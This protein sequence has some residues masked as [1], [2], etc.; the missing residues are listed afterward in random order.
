TGCQTGRGAR[1]FEKRYCVRDHRACEPACRALQSATDPPAVNGSRRGPR[2]GFCSGFRARAERYDLRHCRRVSGLHDIAGARCDAEMRKPRTHEY[3]G[4]TVPAGR[5]FH[6][7]LLNPD[8]NF[9]K[10]IQKTKSGVSVILGTV[11]LSNPV[12][13]LSSPKTRWIFERL[14][15]EFAIIIV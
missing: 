8:D 15:Q 10:Y 11:P 2:Y 7:L 1:Q 14:K 9:D 4:L 5:G 12:A 13:A 6:N 3:F